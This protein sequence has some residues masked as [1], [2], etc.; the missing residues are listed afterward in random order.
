MHVI[1][2][3]DMNILRAIPKKGHVQC[4]PL[5]LGHEGN[6]R[7]GGRK[8]RPHQLKLIAEKHWSNHKIEKF[9]YLKEGEGHIA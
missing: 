1:Y 7:S 4:L 9:T 8:L 3:W 2:S 6:G 5:T